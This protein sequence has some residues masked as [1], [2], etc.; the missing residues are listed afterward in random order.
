MG[1]FVHPILDLS[2]SLVMVNVYDANFQVPMLSFCRKQ[3][4]CFLM[5]YLFI[6]VLFSFSPDKF[7]GD[8]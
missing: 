2:I 1:F 5:A 7:P 4:F 8:A 3:V 6:M